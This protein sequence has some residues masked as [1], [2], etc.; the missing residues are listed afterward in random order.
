[1]SDEV[2]ARRDDF[3]GRNRN[4]SKAFYRYRLEYII[5]IIIIIISPFSAALAA[6][7]ASPVRPA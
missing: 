7:E 5:I 6:A 1:M 3:V 4:L 2:L